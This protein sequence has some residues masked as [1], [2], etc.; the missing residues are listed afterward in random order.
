LPAEQV[1]E[2]SDGRMH[3]SADL[4]RAVY[5]AF[6]RKDT[7]IGAGFSVLTLRGNVCVASSTLGRVRYMKRAAV[8]V[9]LA[10]DPKAAFATCHSAL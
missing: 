5:L 6:S 3:H 7:H 8:L 2:L 10:A 4:V 1:A 9:R